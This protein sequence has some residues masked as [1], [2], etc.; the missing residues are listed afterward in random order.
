MLLLDRQ[1]V[2]YLIIINQRYRLW[3]FQVSMHGNV[4]IIQA[5]EEISSDKV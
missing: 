5:K 4:D 2:S 1:T 3:E